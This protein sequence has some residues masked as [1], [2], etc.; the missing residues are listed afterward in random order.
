VAAAADPMPLPFEDDELVRLAQSRQLGIHP[1]RLLDGDV[2]IGAAVHDQHGHVDAF[3]PA[4]SRSRVHDVG[5]M[6]LEIGPDEGRVLRLRPPRA[7]RGSRSVN[8]P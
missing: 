2:V 4:E 1:S 5:A 6:L 3:G 8:A 7:I